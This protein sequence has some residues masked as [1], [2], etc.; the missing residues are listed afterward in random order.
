MYQEASSDKAVNDQTITLSLPLTV[1]WKEA[2]TATMNAAIVVRP[3]HMPVR[4]MAHVTS[5]SGQSESWPGRY[6]RCK[7]TKSNEG[8]LK[9]STEIVQSLTFGASLITQFPSLS[10]PHTHDI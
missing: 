8:T 7:G 2:T 1:C 9:T 10:V 4:D 6:S 3:P 5:R